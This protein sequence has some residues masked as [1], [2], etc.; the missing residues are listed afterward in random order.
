M[1]NLLF[2]LLVFMSSCASTLYDNIRMVNDYS[3]E[4]RIL[5][6][7]F[8]EVYEL[9]KNGD[10]VI[11]KIFYYTHKKTGKEMTHIQ[12]HYRLNRYNR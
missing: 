11:D 2:I 12:Y 7:N 8:P 10:V 1:K 5:K 9:Y 4:M 6:N 3:E